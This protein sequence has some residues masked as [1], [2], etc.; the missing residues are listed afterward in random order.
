MEKTL[1]ESV[2]VVALATCHRATDHCQ[3]T[4]NFS[5]SRRCRAG[6][7]I[8]TR[9]SFGWAGLFGGRP[10][11]Q[12]GGGASFGGDDTRPPVSC[13]AAEPRRPARAAG[14][15]GGLRGRFRR[16]PILSLLAA[17]FGAATV[18]A[19][20]IAEGLHIGGTGGGAT[21][22]WNE[23]TAYIADTPCLSTPTVPAKP[24]HFHCGGPDGLIRLCEDDDG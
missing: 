2:A 24:Q 21:S 8:I 11:I 9:S 16:H 12:C 7:P 19:I 23:P 1:K 22:C 15:W 18:A 10:L 14:L 4:V 5:P 17:A 20:A 13:D 3:W 6:W